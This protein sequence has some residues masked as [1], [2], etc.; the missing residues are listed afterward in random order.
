MMVSQQITQYAHS[1][2]QAL[3]L[4]RGAILQTPPMYSALKRDGQPLY[5]LARAGE[6][7]VRE[8]RPVEVYELHSLARGPPGSSPWR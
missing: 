8:P 5:R 1:L 2:E 6:T 7:V 3:A 4:F